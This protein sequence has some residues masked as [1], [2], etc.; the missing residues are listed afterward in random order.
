MTNEEAIRVF[1]ELKITIK[2]Q[3]SYVYE[4]LD[5]AY[6]KLKKAYDFEHVIIEHPVYGYCDGWIDRKRMLLFRNPI[7]CE[8]AKSLGY[9]WSTDNE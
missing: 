5:F 4:A 8:I 3:P 2:N 6:K 1:D 9:K 7:T